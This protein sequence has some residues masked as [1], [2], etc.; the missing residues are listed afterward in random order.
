MAATPRYPTDH[1]PVIEVRPALG[2]FE[3]FATVVGTRKPGAHGC[4][5]MAYRD[6]RMGNDDRPAY[7]ERECSTEPG[8]G[9]LVYVD[10]VVA[11]WCS[12]APRASYRRLLHSRTIPILDDTDAWPAVCFVVRSGYRKH[13]LMHRLLAGAVEHARAHGAE[14]VEGYPVQTDG[15]RRV[16]VISGYVGSVALFEAAGFE[17][18]AK[19]TGRSGG[20]PRWVMRK[21]L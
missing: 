11:G 12:V 14:L 7:M 4:W 10:D 13:G 6:S 19:T 18:V 16:D 20:R 9:V 1:D 21:H 2:R 5:C 17:R 8:P 3:A 15:G